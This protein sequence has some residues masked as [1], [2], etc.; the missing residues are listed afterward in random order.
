ML[1]HELDIANRLAW[2]RLNREEWERQWGSSSVDQ[3]VSQESTV[4]RTLPRTPVLPIA[5]PVI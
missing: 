5:L 1:S 2:A 3:Q 4:G